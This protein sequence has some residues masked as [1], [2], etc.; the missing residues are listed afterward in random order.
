MKHRATLAFAAVLLLACS[1]TGNAPSVA[2]APVA[3]LPASPAPE[4]AAPEAAPSALHGL[5]FSAAG[6]LWQIGPDGNP[7]QLAA[8]A[9]G[10]AL[11]P[12]G[13]QMLYTSEDFDIYL[14]ELSDCSTQ[15]LTNSPEQ[16][17]LNPRWWPGLTGAALIGVNPEY[18]AGKPA[19]LQIGRPDYQIIDPEVSANDLPAIRPDG[20]VLA[21]A[22]GYEG[23]AVFITLP[24]PDRQ[25]LDLAAFGLNP[26]E[27]RRLDSPAWSPDGRK[28]AWVVSTQQGEDYA[29]ARIELLILDLE[30]RTALRLR[31]YVPLGRGGWPPA[32]VW[33]PDGRW[34]ALNP[35]PEDPTSSGLWV[36]AADGSAE[37]TLTVPH[38]ANTWLEQLA[39]PLWSPDSSALAFSLTDGTTSSLWWAETGVWQPQTLPLPAEAQLIDWRR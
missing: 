12:D 5:I 15:N 9:R 34:L 18:D 16:V 20:Q 29:T 31:P 4:S 27:F 38:P 13:R 17:E 2:P 3:P 36:V 28:L 6:G 19:L 35:W 7:L 37:F 21:Y 8:C 32:P 23:Q 25:P 1:L 30:A 26:T 22:F 24:S 33:S 14:L 10:A 39:P 11:S